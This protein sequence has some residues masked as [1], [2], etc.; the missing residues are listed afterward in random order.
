MLAPDAN[1]ESISVSLVS[2][3]HAEALSQLH[4]VTV[5]ARANSED[6]LRRASAPFA[7][8]E[9][10]SIPWVDRIWDWCFRH[11]FKSN[12]NSRAF[13]PFSYPFGIA[14]E[15]AAWRHMRARIKAG[16]FDVVLR[17]A[18]VNPVCPSVFPFCLRNH[19]IPVVIGPVNGGL[20]WPTGFSQASNQKSWVDQLRI[21]YKFL[22]FSRSTFR[23]AAAIIAGS[24]Q[25]FSEFATYREKLFFVPENGVSSSLCSG[26]PLRSLQDGKLELIFIGGLIP[27]K[28]CDLALRAAAP[29][30]RDGLAHFT[31]IGDG[32]ERSRLERLTQS[33]GIEEA[34]SF[35]GML[36]H[37]GTMQRLRSA[38]VMLFPSVREFGGGVVFEALASGVV[39]VV[40]D[41][42]G[43]GDIVYPDVGR[44]FS[45]TNE[46]DVLSQLE[47]ILAELI[48]DRVLLDRLRQQGMA[49]ARERLTWE[50]KA[51][52]VTLILNW[53]L[54]R[55]PKPDF[56]PPKA[57]EVGIRSSQAMAVQHTGSQE[58]A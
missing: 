31:V 34:V 6:A 17:V 7:S 50:A 27:F 23:Q 51:Q 39:P 54:A 36:P 47:K 40:A 11:I 41:F 53:V 38:D 12:F 48:Q 49:Y 26:T 57:L 19:P 9:A 18:P 14:F 56:P 8:V 30:V 29:F 24:S 25:T 3:R 43:P 58:S 46:S 55:G 10:I 15:W 37:A 5:V 45:L 13:T 52:I 35:C 33:L 2:Y 22:P 20:P 32:P 44:K 1:P 21:V 42:G 16:E 28:A 4:T